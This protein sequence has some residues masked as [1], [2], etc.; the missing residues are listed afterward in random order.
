MYQ[1]IHIQL[2]T[3]STSL[4]NAHRTLR[5]AP[6][7]FDEVARIPAETLVEFNVPEREKNKVLSSFMAHK[8]SSNSWLFCS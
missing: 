7:K 4:A 5:I 3:C 1:L 8:K 6:Y 2:R